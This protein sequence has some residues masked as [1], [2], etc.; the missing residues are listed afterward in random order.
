[1][2]GDGLGV[3]LSDGTVTLRPWSRDDARFWADASANPAIRRYN[4]HVSAKNGTT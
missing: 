1:M 3:T 2:D 4:G